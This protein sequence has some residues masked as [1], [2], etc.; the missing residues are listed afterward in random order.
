MHG[1]EQVP[2]CVMQKQ[3][4]L[5]IFG[6]NFILM[7]TEYLQLFMG[8]KNQKQKHVFFQNFE[9]KNYVSR[10]KNLIIT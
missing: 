8:F 2:T 10:L 5:C 7:K 6:T 3:A 9:S 1:L 4:Y